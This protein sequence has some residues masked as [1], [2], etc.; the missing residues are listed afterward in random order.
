MIHLQV[1]YL[2]V[3]RVGPYLVGVKTRLCKLNL[4]IREANGCLADID[5]TLTLMSHKITI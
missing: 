3:S 2:V 4:V 5:K 1:V